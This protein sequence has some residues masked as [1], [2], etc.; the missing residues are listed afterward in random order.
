MTNQVSKSN[1]LAKM[2]E[3]S[4]SNLSLLPLLSSFSSF[5]L[6]LIFP[7][8]FCWFSAFSPTFSLFHNVPTHFSHEALKYF[9][10]KCTPSVHYQFIWSWQLF[11]PNEPD[12]SSSGSSDPSSYRFLVRICK[13]QKN[14]FFALLC[15]EKDIANL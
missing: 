1:C 5:S 6:S 10:S 9:I 8:V 14:T 15:S 7:L 4:P 11:L 12:V 3:E 2:K 13:S